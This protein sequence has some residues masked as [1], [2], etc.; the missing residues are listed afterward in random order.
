M[1]KMNVLYVAAAGAL[2]VNSAYAANLIKNGS[3]EKPVVTAGGYEQFSTGDTF[4]GWKVVGA[5]GNVAIASG[6][7]EQGGFTFPAAGGSQWLDLTGNS[8][9]ATGVAQ[10]VA[11]TVGTAYTLTFY[12]GNVDDPGGVWGTTSKVNVFVDGTQVYAATNS[13]GAG[14]T[15][16]VWQK[17]ST[18]ITATSAHTTIAFMNGDPPTDNSNGLDLISL[19]EEA[20]EEPAAV[21]QPRVQD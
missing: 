17:F 13:R 10:T 5:T 9:T 14:Q 1:P 15:K 3:F 19:V 6:A 16:L 20:D 7:F 2:L 18:T 4:N 11:T 12:I 8:N 21:P